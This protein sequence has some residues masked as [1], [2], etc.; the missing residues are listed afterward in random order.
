MDGMMRTALTFNGEKIVIAIISFVVIIGNIIGKKEKLM[1]VTLIAWLWVIMS[2]TYGIADESVYISRYNNPDLWIGKTELAYSALI[3]ICNKV[4]FTFQQFKMVV[5]ALELWLIA[6]TVWKYAKY[7]NIILVLYSLYPFALNVAQMRNA[8]ATAIMI[9]ACR[10]LVF[11]NDAGKRMTLS[12][13]KYCCYIILATLVHST[14][15]VWLVLLVAK[16]SDI[17]FT[18]I[19]TLFANFVIAFVLSPSTIAR[20]ANIFGAGSRIGA[21]LTN[22]YQQ[23]SYRHYGIALI[24][25][26]LTALFMTG[27]CI[28]IIRHKK[29][30]VDIDKIDL[31]LKMNV[32][33][34]CIFSIILK[35]TGEAYRL[36]EG[37]MLV[38]YMLITNSFDPS[39]FKMRKLSVRT[40]R[41]LGAMT[42][43]L[44]VIIYITIL[45][46]LVPTIL[47]PI[48]N[49]NYLID[50]IFS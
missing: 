28:Y 6:S 11:D 40:A 29:V 14:S 47:N 25:V 9:Y 10:Y 22:E 12:D 20:V 38:N 19:F 32:V 23:S 41:V 31:L 33:I 16:K 3:S 24:Q 42:V 48:L 21:Y 37:L 35:Y 15:I 8:L 5:S 1:Y 44:A 50:Y 17:K 45:L 7:P 30:F 46:Y 18:F 2:F 4:G 26:I 27:I 36:Q 34:L 13:V 43:F 49:N 39:R